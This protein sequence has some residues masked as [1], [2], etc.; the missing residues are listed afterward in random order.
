[1]DTNGR[2]VMA[3]VQAPMSRESSIL[4]QKVFGTKPSIALPQFEVRMFRWFISKLWV[5]SAVAE[6]IKEASA[7]LIDRSDL[8]QLVRL[9]QED[10]L[11]QV[12]DGEAEG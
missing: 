8:A 12:A 9:L 2:A 6:Q 10:D 7:P 1:M 11:D 5:P 4:L 3:V